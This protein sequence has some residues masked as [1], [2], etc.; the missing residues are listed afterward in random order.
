MVDED[1]GQHI[2]S[3]ERPAGVAQVLNEGAACGG[4]EFW[5]ASP[6]RPVQFVP[7]TSG[8]RSASTG[9]SFAR[10]VVYLALPSSTDINGRCCT[11]AGDAVEVPAKSG[12]LYNVLYTEIMNLDCPDEYL[13]VWTAQQCPFAPTP[14]P[15]QGNF[16]AADDGVTA[17]LADDPWHVLQPDM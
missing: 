2:P 4:L 6:P 8:R 7:G 9:S 3:G 11:Q 17:L 14:M 15:P 16:L 5:R 12:R 13:M 1:A 10:P